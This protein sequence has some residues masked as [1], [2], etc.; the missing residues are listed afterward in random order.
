[1]T[2]CLL[3]IY[4]NNIH[5]FHIPKTTADAPQDDIKGE[6]VVCDRFTDATRAYQGSGRGV[7]T[8]WIDSLALSVH[9]DLQPDR[10]LLLDLPPAVGE[11]HN[12]QQMRMIER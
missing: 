2:S 11:H 4:T 8:A 7:D 6:W 12:E 10:T 1:M 3:N 9:G 5:F